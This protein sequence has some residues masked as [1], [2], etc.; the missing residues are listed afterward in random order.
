MIPAVRWNE[1]HDARYTITKKSIKSTRVPDQPAEDYG[2]VS[3]GKDIFSRY[4]QC[5][6][7]VMK[8]LR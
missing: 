3:P 4:A 2:T 6:S 7:C 1:V 5:L 8:E